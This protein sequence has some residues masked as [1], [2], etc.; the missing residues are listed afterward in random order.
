MKRY[1]VFFLIVLSLSTNLFAASR[2]AIEGFSFDDAE[3][4]TVIKLMSRVTGKSF[5]F[6]KKVL[7]GKKITLLSKQKFTPDEAYK[8]FE[9]VL[10]ING[11]S[12]IREGKVVRIVQSKSAK[13]T[14]SPIYE[15][16]MRLDSGSYITRVI[17]VQNSDIKSL[18]SSLSPLV[19]K[20]AV[21]IADKGARV[22]VLRDTR[23]NT[24]QF[25]KLV[26]FFDEAAD[27]ELKV[28]ME[29]LSIKHASAKDIEAL[30]NNIFK[31]VNKQ[32]YTSVSR[33]KVFS[34]TRTNSLVLIG[35][36]TSMEK[37]KKLI[38]E[39]DHRVDKGRGS[40]GGNIRVY[41]LKSASA[42]SVAEVLQKVA[43]TFTSGNKKSSITIIPDIPSNSLVIHAEAQ[44]FPSLEGV[45][46]QLDVM[47]PQ[48]YIQA[49]IME[50][51]LNRSLDLGVEWQ[52]GNKTAY[53]NED[54]YISGGGVGS[55]GTLNSFPAS[56]SGTSGAILGIVGGPV[57]FGD[58]VYT[59]F[60]SFIKANQQDTDIDILANPQILTLNNEEAEIKVG[61]VIPTVSSTRVDSNGNE[62]TSIDYKEVGVKL[63]ITPQINSN[64]SIELQIDET[65]SSVIEGTVGA[66]AQGAI[67]TL[68]RSIKTKIV[69]ND[70]QT[71]ALGGL[72]NDSVTIV[73][74]KT[75]CLGDIPLMGWLFKTNSDKTTKTNLFVF[76]TPRVIK[77]FKDLKEA[78]NEAKR[79][80]VKTR[81]GKFRVDVSKEF[82]LP[83]Q[84]GSMTQDEIKEAEEKEREKKKKQPLKI[85]ADASKGTDNIEATE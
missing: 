10:E 36:P 26:A 44:H 1:L 12:T 66:T 4:T 73:E 78:T 8:I 84:I 81:K 58:K 64:G 5:V 2:Q 30:I 52:A 76:L 54:V 20:N 34:D 77:N 85:N 17:P 39:L 61:E 62:T 55:T 46:E 48:V 45:L 43:K 75:P 50:V 74:T 49:L 53:G 71:A 22:L 51:R 59:S 32:N 14:P 3:V 18:R 27:K 13:I 57:T 31:E 42:K 38:K 56:P 16:G 21:L 72:I 79:Q 70:G 83:K 37:F 69:V 80:N 24:E 23:E 28:H 6:N 40:S 9:A 25:A 41:T 82:G 33:L 15:K 7:T 67:T 11:L 19:S 63:K 47:R 60:S 68:N 35:N 29:V 65:N